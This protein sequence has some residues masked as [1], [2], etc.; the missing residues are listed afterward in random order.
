MAFEVNSDTWV[1]VVIEN[2]GG[3]EQFVGQHHAKDDIS[4]IPAFL[5]KEEAA[6]CYK[7]LA[8]TEGSKYE[9]TAIQ[10]DHLTQEAFKNGF[11]IFFLD[12]DGE[13]IHRASP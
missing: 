8:L 9:V 3:N 13:I 2:P 12:E 7:R 5:K 4:F 10:Y 6:G 1:W 11:S